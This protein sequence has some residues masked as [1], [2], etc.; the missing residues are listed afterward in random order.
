M[1]AFA[2]MMRRK[3]RMPLGG[4]VWLVMLAL[5]GC[6]SVPSNINNACTIL[7][8][9]GGWFNNWY[10]QTKEVERQFGVP[11]P[12]TLATIRQE[13]GFQS[14]AKPPMQYFLWIIPIGRASD[15]FGYPQALDSTWAYYQQKT[16]NDGAERDDFE[17]A[18]NFVGWYYARSHRINGIALNDAYHLYLTYYFGQTGFANGSWRNNSRVKQIARKVQHYANRYRQQMQQCGYEP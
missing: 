13:S 2:F 3:N 7:N 17:D 10:D 5:S 16:G 8:E 9:N 18:V 14:D 6:A 11:V 15:A 12:V 1:S 4:L